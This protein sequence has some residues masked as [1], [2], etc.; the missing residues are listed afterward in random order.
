MDNDL[1]DFFFRTMSHE[2]GSC[3]SSL[4]PREHPAD[5][6]TRSWEDNS[7]NRNVTQSGPHS[8]SHPIDISLSHISK[9]LSLFFLNDSFLHFLTFCLSLPSLPLSPAQRVVEAAGLRLRVSEECRVLL[10]VSQQSALKWFLL[11]GVCVFPEKLL[12][13]RLPP[14]LFLKHTHT[15]KYTDLP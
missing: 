9:S 2:A 12:V 13:C 10:W 1:T 14:A 15:H 7:K 6:Q 5:A 8:L 3:Y 4:Q 11:F